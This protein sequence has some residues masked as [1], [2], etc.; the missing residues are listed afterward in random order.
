MRPQLAAVVRWPIRASEMSWTGWAKFCAGGRVGGAWP[1]VASLSLGSLRSPLCDR[2]RYTVGLFPSWPRRCSDAQAV[3]AFAAPRGAPARLRPV[4]VGLPTLRAPRR[5]TRR[6]AAMRC[7][8]APLDSPCHAAWLGMG[9]ALVEWKGRTVPYRTTGPAARS[10]TPM[11]G[12][13]GGQRVPLECVLVC[14]HS[15]G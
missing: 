4:P 12:L 10:A 1:A 7:R 8:D 15:R 13:C 11:P 14:V 5:L 3:S 9:P 6:D 2:Y